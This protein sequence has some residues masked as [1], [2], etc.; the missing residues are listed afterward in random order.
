[1][2]KSR[3]IYKLT[4]EQ[5]RN[6]INSLLP[7]ELTRAKK[8]ITG[9]PSYICP[10][11]SNGSG[12]SGTGICTNNGKHYKCFVCDFYGDYLDLLKKQHGTDSENEIFTRYNLKIENGQPLPSEPSSQNKRQETLQTDYRE[13]FLQANKNL[14][15]SPDGLSYLQSRGISVTT[16]DRFKLGYVLEWTHPAAPNAP[17]TARIIIP[18]SKYSY[19]ARA[20][21]PA[22]NIQKQKVGASLPFNMKALQNKDHQFI[23]VTEGEFDALSVVEVGG[24][25]IALGGSGTS[26]FI[27]FVKGSKPSA[28][29]VLSLDNDKRGQE[30]QPVL[31]KRLQIL[32]IPC[33][34]ASIP[35]E[36]KD[37]NE[38]LQNDRAVLECFVQ[39]PANKIEKK[40]A[41]IQT[42][43]VNGSL[44]A[45]M[46]T[47]SDKSATKAIPIG[48]K[49]LD[50]ILDG[51]LYE[52]L[53]IIGAISGI[54]KTTFILQIADQ[55]AQQGN[56][57]I[58]FS[59]EMSKD[60]LISKSISRLMFEKT[61]HIALTSRQI[62][63]GAFINNRF[64]QETLQI[65]NAYAQNLYI[66]DAM[67]NIG[68]EQI[69]Q[70]IKEHIQITDNK[71]VVIIDYL[72]ILNPCDTRASDKQNIDKSVL[73]LKSISMEHKIPVLAVSSLNRDNYLNSVNMASFKESGAIE[74]SS[75][76]LIGLQFVGAGDKTFDINIKQKA[77]PRKIELIILKNRQGASGD[78]IKFDFD[79]RFN[80][81]KEAA[82]PQKSNN[83]IR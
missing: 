39:D 71:P 1:M 34:E 48:F 36:Y 30:V 80:H 72:Q 73:E 55:I 77:N 79:A 63:C 8:D 19:L 57:V 43:S 23:F 33:I 82:N 50:K 38:I 46:Q 20:I 74:Y 4:R 32:N 16:A 24:Q 3:G 54:G 42:N 44:N 29:F 60:T 37:L 75:D 14:H 76:V 31:K 9:Y 83:N 2:A 17:V 12:E 56:D 26:K 68:T 49:K 5:A 58:I 61:S 41:Y 59:L 6:H 64:I 45:F 10:F 11:C 28:T 7:V 18:I 66:Y 62:M 15:D 27:E 21:D 52:G 81:F 69:K 51:G 53:Y 47:I 78:I 40:L 70:T 35:K 25:A 22:A 67:G 65:Y 13:F